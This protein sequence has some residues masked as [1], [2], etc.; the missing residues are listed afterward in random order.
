MRAT[1]RDPVI[2]QWQLVEVEE[3]IVPP[4]QKTTS[5]QGKDSGGM[6]IQVHACEKSAFSKVSLSATVY[7]VG[8]MI[9]AGGVGVSFAGFGVA[10]ARP[11]LIILTRSAAAL[12]FWPESVAGVE[13]PGG[14]CGFD[15]PPAI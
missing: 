12:S 4:L 1:E 5:F 6:A 8:A 7:E 15:W 3:V 10:V 14:P 2:V 11:A 9:V 13:F